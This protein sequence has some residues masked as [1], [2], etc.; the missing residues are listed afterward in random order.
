MKPCVNGQTLTPVTGATL[1]LDDPS[2]DSDALAQASRERYGV[3]RSDVEASLAARLAVG[4][5][6]PGDRFGRETTGRRR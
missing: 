4:G 6:K 5:P 2:Q 1:P 3:A